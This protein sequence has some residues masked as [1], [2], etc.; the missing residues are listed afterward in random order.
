ME[1]VSKKNVAKSKP[2][3]FI[4]GSSRTEYTIHSALVAHQ[5]SALGVLV[6]GNFQE[7]TDFSVHWE[8]IDEIVFVSFWQF[9]Y[10][11]D[12]DTPK[13]IPPTTETSSKQEVSPATTTSGE[14]VPNQQNTQTPPQA[15]NSARSA[16]QTKTAEKEKKFQELWRKF[17][18][19]WARPITTY[20]VDETLKEYANP[21]VHHAK[22]YTLADRYAIT[23]LME[24]SFNR[25]HQSLMDYYTRGG[26]DMVV[27]LV[28][29]ACE[30]LVPD[31]LRDLVVHYVTC[32]VEHLWEFKEFQELVEKH[33]VLSKELV[34]MMLLR[35]D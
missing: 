29:F 8:D 3:K 7:S 23:R 30:N 24:V 11:G 21:L 31:D 32:T 18:N 25:L 17:R 27:E 12:Y 35:L 19:D 5:S 14:Q 4:V 9:A 28:R 2:F 26:E 10:T 33:G 13:P 34:G 22:V 6:N 1:G 16:P 20:E 15:Y